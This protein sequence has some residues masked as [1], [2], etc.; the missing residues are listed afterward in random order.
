MGIAEICQQIDNA[1]ESQM[2]TKAL[3]RLYYEIDIHGWGDEG[4]GGDEGDGG[5]AGTRRIINRPL[6]KVRYSPE[7]KFSG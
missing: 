7:N 4:G 3:K 1:I 5:D 6:A 2:H